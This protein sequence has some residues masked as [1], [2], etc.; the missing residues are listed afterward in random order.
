MTFAQRDE[1]GEERRAPRQPVFNI[2]GVILVIIAVI[3]GIHAWREYGLSHAADASLMRRFAFV[4]GRLTA[5][6]DMEAVAQALNALAREPAKMAAA[7]YFLGDGSP[8]PW[9][10]LSYAFLHGDWLHAG[11]NSMWLAAFGGPVA[12]RFG[13]LR[14]LLLFALTALAGAGA[15]YLFHRGDFIPVAGAS[16]AVSGAMA[17]AAR[18]VFQP[19]A[20]LGPQTYGLPLPPELAARLPAISLGAA[21]RDKRVLQFTLIWFAIN[22]VFGLYSQPLGITS[23]AVAWEAHAGGFI[24]GFVLFSLL[25]PPPPDPRIFDGWLDPG[26][27]DPQRRGY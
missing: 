6:F 24:A 23:S 20:P 14:F 1:N 12:A 17:A 13:W 3:L 7:R 10:V 4:P 18:F 2:P 5:I 22:L 26:W 19:G 16:A 25:D 11:L 9:T 8:Q 27:H 21:L 15:H